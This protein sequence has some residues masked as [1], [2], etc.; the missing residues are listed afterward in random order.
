MPQRELASKYG[1]DKLTIQEFSIQET[2]LSIKDATMIRSGVEF[3]K[4]QKLI[5][6]LSIYYEFNGIKHHYQLPNDSNNSARIFGLFVTKDF[7]ASSSWL[8]KFKIRHD[9]TF[10]KFLIIIFCGFRISK[11]VSKTIETLSATQ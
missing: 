11:T 8:N 9:L 4:T 1:V 5:N 2:K 7:K 10:K 6:K 3:Q